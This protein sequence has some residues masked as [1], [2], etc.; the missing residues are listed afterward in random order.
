MTHGTADTTTNSQQLLLCLRPP[1]QA[2]TSQPVKRHLE[3]HST[4]DCTQSSKSSVKLMKAFAIALVQ[5]AMINK[6]L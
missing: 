4:A 1:Q 5:S 3:Q 6:P 2:E